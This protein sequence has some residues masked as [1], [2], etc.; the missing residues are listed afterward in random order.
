MET[1]KFDTLAEV[2]K[3][4]ILLVLEKHNFNRSAT[5][6]ILDIGLRTLQRKCLE[7]GVA[8]ATYNRGY[9]RK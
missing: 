7:Y 8:P 4:Y 1:E 9:T 6:R 5:A 2:E 3:R